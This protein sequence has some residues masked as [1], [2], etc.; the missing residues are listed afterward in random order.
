M[1]L[2]F[3]QVVVKTFGFLWICYDLFF[4][5]FYGYKWFGYN[6][7]FYQMNGEMLVKWLG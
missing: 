7:G 4:V 1:E 6:D 3:W 2:C 5:F